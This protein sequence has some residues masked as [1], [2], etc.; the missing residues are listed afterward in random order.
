M[1]PKKGGRKELPAYWSEPVD[2]EPF[3]GLKART[4]LLI[5]A[6]L[7]ASCFPWKN[8]ELGI[9]FEEFEVIYFL[10]DIN[11]LFNVLT[12]SYSLQAR[13]LIR[14]PLGLFGTIL[15]VK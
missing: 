6:S 15:G 11:D 4:G 8:K 13:D 2:C 1:G 5:K 10:H 12:N 9:Q 3:G 14:T 7:A